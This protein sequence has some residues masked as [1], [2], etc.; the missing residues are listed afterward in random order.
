MVLLE[1]EKIEMG[2]PAPDFRLMGVDDEMHSLSDYD[3]KDVLVVMFICNHCPYVKA[4]FNRLFALVDYFDGKSVQFVGVNSNINPSYPDDS[5]ENMK[6]VDGLNFPYLVDEAQDVARA[7]GAQCTPD[8]FVYDKGRGL[9]Y[10]GR[11]DDNWKDEEAVEKEDL[12]EAVEG[13]LVGGIV[14]IQKPSMGCSIKW[15]HE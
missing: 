13:A 5:F 14:E 1:S 12:K 15:M 4:V 8:I 7:Y 2:T 6:L 11:I 10:H 3:D 9:V